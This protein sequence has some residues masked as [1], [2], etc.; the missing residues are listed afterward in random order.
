M[1]M[2]DEKEKRSKLV[3]YL[4]HA[5]R[6]INFILLIICIFMNLILV[7]TMLLHFNVGIIPFILNLYNLFI[8]YRKYRR[9]KK[10]D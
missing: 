3:I 8:L 5:Y 1:F 4:I 2:D 10:S 7:I 6:K 9:E